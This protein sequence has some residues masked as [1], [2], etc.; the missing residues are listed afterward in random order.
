MRFASHPRGSEGGCKSISIIGR[1]PGERVI[2]AL[3]TGLASTGDWPFR[4]DETEPGG[5]DKPDRAIHLLNYWGLG[6]D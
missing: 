4:A 6:P 5:L 2:H 3:P 1:I